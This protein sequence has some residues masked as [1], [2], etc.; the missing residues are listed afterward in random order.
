VPGEVVWP[1]VRG[2][3]LRVYKSERPGLEG[4]LLFERGLLLGGRYKNKGDINRGDIKTRERY[5]QGRYKNK[6]DI[7]TR[8]IYKQ[9]RYKQG[10]Y[11]ERRNRTE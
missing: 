4:G 7:K 8:E 1:A 5:K 2:W 10:R 9:G 11:R 6:G 3:E